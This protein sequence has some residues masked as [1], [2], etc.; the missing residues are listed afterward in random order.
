MKKYFIK[1]TVYLLLLILPLIGIF[2]YVQSKPAVFSESLLG[3]INHK[4]KL[5]DEV[6][7]P[8]IVFVG[9]SS[10]PYATNCERISS[11]L[12]MPCINI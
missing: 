9:G 10:C 7:S 3:T 8:R 12:G 6:D 5:L 2:A 4:Y 1:L 11:E